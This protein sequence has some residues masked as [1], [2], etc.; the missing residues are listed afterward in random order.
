MD[1]LIAEAGTAYFWLTAVLLALAVNIASSYVKAPLDAILSRYSKRRQER[2][3][4]RTAEA[5]KQAAWLAANLHYAPFFVASELRR[6]LLGI[7]LTIVA[8]SLFYLGTRTAGQ[9]PVSGLFGAIAQLVMVT[10]G[11]AVFIIGAALISTGIDEASLLR[12]ARE[13]HQQA[14]DGAEPLTSRNP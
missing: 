6:Y 3:A 4:A 7:Y 14:A 1:K 2:N 8:V 10:V 9:G 11:L 12:R 5:E 13:L